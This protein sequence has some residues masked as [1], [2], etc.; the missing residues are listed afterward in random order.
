MVSETAPGPGAPAP[1][2]TPSPARAALGRLA[3]VRLTGRG[4]ALLISGGVLVLVGI[5][6]ELPD[7]V[8]LGAAGMLA[9]GCA[10][11]VMGVQRLDAGRGAL[12]VARE[13]TPNPVVRDR[14][15]AVRLVVGARSRTGA[16]YE[17]LARL[18]LS[19]QAAH[20]LAG[21]Q[22]IR[23]R[24]TAHPD[25]ITVGYTLHPTRRGRWPLGPLLTTRTDAFGLVRTTQSLGEPS[26]VAVR[27]RTLPLPTR[28]RVLGDVDHIAT[29]ARL[30]STDDSVL[31]EYVSGDDP[32]RV[33]WAV[34]ARQGRLMVRADESAGVRPVT[35]LLDCSLLPPPA[36]NRGGSWPTQRGVRQLEDAEHAVELAASVAV[37]F[38]DSGHPAR[39]VST[40]AGATGFA[41][42]ARTGRSAVLDAAVDLHGHRTAAEAQSAVAATARSLR[43]GR[44]Q[45]EITVAVL[46]PLPDAARSEVASLASD[47][48]CW[49]VVVA[50]S[51]PRGGLDAE[52]TATDLRHAG[53]QVA[54]C[55]AG[56][57]ADRA[58]ALLTERAA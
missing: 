38:L 34:S 26:L 53:W 13:L 15:T 2:T 47:G 37:S 51:D 56:T 17:R 49:A 50:P 16:A 3:R 43:L 35:V 22:G 29:G 44:T 30:A 31:R 41:P 11:A 12:V 52:R 19:E 40:G 4:Y 5:L 9:V 18:R 39:L 54:V 21:P 25:R 23:A 46:A 42:G 32:R 20:E 45:A 6:L 33:H 14:S 24:V 48:T 36:D 7:V 27:P 1:G 58:W 8:G 57:P 10:W 55:P 28:T